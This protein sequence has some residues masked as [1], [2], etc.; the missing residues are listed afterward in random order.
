MFLLYTLFPIHFLSVHSHSCAIVPYCI[1]PTARILSPF[2]I[3]HHFPPSSAYCYTLK[4]EVTNIF[5]K[6][7]TYLRI[8]GVSNSP[9]ITL[10]IYLSDN[11][12]VLNI[13]DNSCQ[14]NKECRA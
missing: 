6:A 7:D 13:K 9:K 14:Y 3:S 5:R 1:S 4:R 2:P 8:Y 11:L 12:K 10:H